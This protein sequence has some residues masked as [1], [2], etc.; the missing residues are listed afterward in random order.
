MREQQ[1]WPC[2]PWPLAA[3]KKL[4]GSFGKKRSNDLHEPEYLG[5]EPKQEDEHRFDMTLR[6]WSST[7]GSGRTRDREQNPAGPCPFIWSRDRPISVSMPDAHTV[8][9]GDERFDGRWEFSEV[10]HCAVFWLSDGEMLLQEVG[11]DDHEISS[12][13]GDDSSSSTIS[14]AKLQRFLSIGNS[15]YKVVVLNSLVLACLAFVMFPSATCSNGLSTNAYFAYVPVLVGVKSFER[16]LINELRDVPDGLHARAFEPDPSFDSLTAI[17]VFAVL[18]HMDF[19]TDL[20][21]IDQA[22]ACEEH[23]ISLLFANAWG[24]VP[25]VGTLAK[26]IFSKCSFT[27]IIVF[28]FVAVVLIPQILFP[29]LQS[30]RLLWKQPHSLD[31]DGTGRQVITRLVA[32]A[33]AG[34]M[35]TLARAFQYS[36][37]P[38]GERIRDVSLYEEDADAGYEDVPVIA[39]K[40][41]LENLIQLVMQSS[42]F[43]LVFSLMNEQARWKSLA[44]ITIGSL[45]ALNKVRQVFLRGLNG[46][47]CL[48]CLVCA[49][50]GLLVYVFFAIP[51]NIVHQCVHGS[52]R[53]CFARGTARILPAVA[54]ITIGLTLTR[55]VAA[56]L[57]P[58]HVWNLTTGCLAP[59]ALHEH[60]NRT[61]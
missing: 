21:F 29:L 61:A 1:A 10:S 16:K 57:C 5:H 54:C 12:F 18:D 4:T 8:F 59:Y 24:K 53:P 14:E 31:P 28:L 58:A 43:G 15:M 41:V 48:F 25:L 13:D 27:H 46:V 44:S 32:I 60:S 26:T 30:H 23:N 11:F 40:T 6:M 9:L 38:P 56:F 45:V 50:C 55:T 33:D 17:A 52:D 39:R 49:P 2:N 20:A 22:A 36:T 35:L 7:V 37:G 47:E 42:F 3:G 51:A 19:F 34:S